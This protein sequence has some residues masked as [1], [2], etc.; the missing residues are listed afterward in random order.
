M[1]KSSRNNTVFSCAFLFT[2]FLSRVFQITCQLPKTPSIPQNTFVPM[3][4][5]LPD[6]GYV[7]VQM[8]QNQSN[9]L[10]C[11]HDSC[12]FHYRSSPLSSACMTCRV[13]RFARTLFAP[14]F[15][16]GTFRTLRFFLSHPSSGGTHS[17]GEGGGG[18]AS[19]AFRSG[20]PCKHRQMFGS[21][22]SVA[23]NCYLDF[24]EEFKLKVA[25]KI[26]RFSC[27]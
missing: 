10:A 27:F 1:C 3:I 18:G 25:N 7:F 21:W 2:S 15:S 23:Y 11:V 17:D 22:A 26:V 6:L 8:V 16:A 14:A 20:V 5:W 12:G 24:S 9:R 19:W 13:F 4:V